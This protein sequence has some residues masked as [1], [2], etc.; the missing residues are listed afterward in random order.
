MKPTGKFNPLGDEIMQAELTDVA[1]DKNWED[2]T[3]SE[4]ATFCS[5][6]H[7]GFLSKENDEWVKRNF[8][9]KKASLSLA[10]LKLNLNK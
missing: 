8:E 9:S 1:W 7:I 3:L 2:L 10:I 4:K 6:A 5:F